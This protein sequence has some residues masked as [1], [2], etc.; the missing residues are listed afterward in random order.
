MK[1]FLE[2]AKSYKSIVA[3]GDI[4][5]K[6]AEF[7]YFIK[8]RYKIRN[9][10]ICICGDVGFGFHKLNYYIKEWKHLDKIAKKTNNLIIAVRGNHDD[11]EYFNGEFGPNMGFTNILLV[12]DYT[13]IESLNKRILFVGGGVSIDRI[14]RINT[15]ARTGEICYWPNEIPV[16]DETKLDAAGNVDIIITHSAPSYVEPLSKCGL[17]YW[18]RKDQLLEKDCIAE[19]MVFTKIYD[20]LKSKCIHP[21]Y[22]IYGHFHKS[23]SQYLNFTKFRMLSKFE[24]YEI[25]FDEQ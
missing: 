8:A 5:G 4:H 22:W 7:G 12:P 13:I 25:L 10:I 20:F 15:T 14:D 23:H 2:R 24:F 21:K 9:S 1:E 19:R 18:L 6:F 17:N 3:V 16:Y 11:P